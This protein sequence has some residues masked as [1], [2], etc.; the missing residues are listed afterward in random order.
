MLFSVILVPKKREL[1]DL[2]KIAEA[3]KS[4]TQ[5]LRTVQLKCYENPCESPI[6]LN[7]CYSGRKTVQ[8]TKEGWRSGSLMGKVIR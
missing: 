7:L 2:L 4:E 8:M 3:V 5:S 1:P 6:L